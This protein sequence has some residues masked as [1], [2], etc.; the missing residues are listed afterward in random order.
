MEEQTKMRDVMAMQFAAALIQKGD[1]TNSY[2]IARKACE[3]ANIM[4]V[5]LEEE[6]DGMTP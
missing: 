4:V 2:E 6:A 5:V 3:M 1:Y